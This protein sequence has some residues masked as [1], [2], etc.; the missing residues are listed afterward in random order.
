[1]CLEAPVVTTNPACLSVTVSPHAVAGQ[2][3]EDVSGPDEA[4]L[5]GHLKNS[6]CLQNHDGL[7][8][9]LEGS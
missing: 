5:H 8:N 7:L 9:D 4:V 2:E 6:E 3:D 1:M